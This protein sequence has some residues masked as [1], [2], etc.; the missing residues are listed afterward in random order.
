MT[1]VRS[2]S[3][4][5]ARWSPRRG[6]LRRFG[7]ARSGATAVEFAMI[8]M[9]FLGLVFATLEL[10]MMFLVSTTM[11]SSAQS[12]ARTIRTGQFQSGAATAAVYKDAVCNGMGWL[13]ADCETNLRIDVRTF[14]TFNAV[15]TA[16]PILNAADVVFQ[17]GQACSIVLARA[18]YSWTL[19]APGLSGVTYTGAGK[20]KLQSAAAFRNEPFSGQI[21]PPSVP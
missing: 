9:P 7:R 16:P 18:S 11:E 1:D 21:C 17:P 4:A 13:Q 2:S 3:P 8:V 6:F 19:L 15:N 20:V 10:G 5:T 12:A 14:N